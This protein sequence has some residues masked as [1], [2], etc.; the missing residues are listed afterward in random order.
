LLP[1]D[2]LKLAERHDLIADAV[3]CEPRVPFL[4]IKYGDD[5]AGKD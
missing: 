2:V 1:V 4:R 3:H 5:L